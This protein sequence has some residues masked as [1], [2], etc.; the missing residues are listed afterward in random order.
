MGVIG[1]LSLAAVDILWEDLKL[2]GIP[3]PLEVRAHGDTAEERGRIR[4]AVYAQLERRGLASSGRPTAELEDTLTLLAAPKISIDLVALCEMTDETPLRAVVAARGKRAVLAVQRELAISL[5]E[6]RETAIVGSIVDLLP[7]NRSGPGQSVT[8]PASMLGAR[9]VVS[10]GRH[11]R[12]D[13]AGPL[14]HTAT[15][16]SDLAGE[17]RFVDSVTER[18]T[19][20]A[21]SIGIVLRDERGKV[22]R[23]PGI[24]FFDTDLGRYATSVM[25]GADGEDW[26]TLSPADNARLA[27]RL[28]ETL[29]TALQS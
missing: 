24:G 29:V 15:R 26:T 20:A 13:S 1:D 19:F 8:L 28:A 9:S 23:L 14:L 11:R 3:F 5:S 10:V 2:G 25:R 22:Q 16:E 7:P 21:G 6:V 12:A 17:L 4:A 27:H 18:P